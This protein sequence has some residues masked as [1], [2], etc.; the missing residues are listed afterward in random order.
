MTKKNTNCF[1]ANPS[2]DCNVIKIAFNTF[3]N[4]KAAPV[5]AKAITNATIVS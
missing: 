5:A 1:V 3:Q 2:R 4:S